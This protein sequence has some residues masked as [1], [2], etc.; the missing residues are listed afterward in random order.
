MI[1][2]PHALEFTNNT[3]KKNNVQLAVRNLTGNNI[4]TRSKHHRLKLFGFLTVMS[5]KIKWMF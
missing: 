3:N 2:L 1:L 5:R 4:Q